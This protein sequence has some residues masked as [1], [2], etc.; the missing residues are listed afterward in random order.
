MT[1]PTHNAAADARVR[2]RFIIMNVARLG[3]VVLVMLGFAII[4]RVVDLPF[5]LG[6]VLAVVG[7]VDFFAAPILLAR[8]WK[9]GGG[10]A[11]GKDTPLP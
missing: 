1:Q 7:F 5:A 4:Q 2:N 3:G 8:R 6:V 10:S 9:S 11:A